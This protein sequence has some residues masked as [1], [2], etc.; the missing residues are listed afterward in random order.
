MAEL[1]YTR[2]GDYYIPD[3]ILDEEPEQDVFYGKYGDLRRDYLRE[4]K[5]KLWMV[6]VNSGKMTDHLKGIE[7]M[8]EQRMDTLL[9]QLLKAVGVTE[10]LKAR[11]QMAW[12]G[13]VLTFEKVMEL[14]KG[15]LAE[16]TRYEIV[17]T[18]RGYTVL[19]WDSS[20][21]TWAGEELCA[22]PEIMRVV[23][24]D[25]FTG[26]LE[27]KAITANGEITKAEQERITAR[28]QVLLEKPQ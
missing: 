18:S 17:M 3:L 22:T 7:R 12:V 1:T 10:E 14:F 9:P 20:A 4:H 21:N 16:D 24:L 13:L 27:Y 6:Q 5:P 28:R 2:V 8:A 23:L 19:G 15:Y 11:D 25:C 26:Y